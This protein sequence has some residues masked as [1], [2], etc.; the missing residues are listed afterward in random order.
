MRSKFSEKP[1]ED[2]TETHVKRCSLSTTAIDEIVTAMQGEVAVHARD[3]PAWGRPTFGP[4][5]SPRFGACSWPD[6]SEQGTTHWICDQKGLIALDALKAGRIER[7]PVTANY[8]NLTAMPYVIP[9]EEIAAEFARDPDGDD[10]GLAVCHRLAPR[11]MAFLE[12]ALGDNPDAVVQLQRFAG[13]CLTFDMKFETICFLFGPSGS[14]KGT[15]L[16]VLIELVGQRNAVATSYGE[17]CNRF[18]LIRLIGKPLAYIDEAGAIGHS[19][20]GVE[21][22]RRLKTF[23]A[24]T[25]MG[26]EAKHGAKDDFTPVSKLVLAADQMP[27]LTDAAA[28]MARRLLVIPFVQSH[29]GRE[30]YDLKRKLKAEIAGVAAWAIFGLRSLYRVGRF[31]QPAKGAE[32]LGELQR[33]WSPV[34]AFCEDCVVTQAGSRCTKEV[35]YDLY[36]AW[37]ENEGFEPRTKETFSAQLKAAVPTVRVGRH[38]SGGGDPVPWFEGVRPKLRRDDYEH[39]RFE[40]HAVD[41]GARSLMGPFDF[42]Y[43]PNQYADHGPALIPT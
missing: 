4:D 6:F 5:G 40:A 7:R 14:G 8:I 37:C 28:A 18:E 25:P 24:G 20:D 3:L 30:D 35:M 39:R 9:V 36:R 42:E 16:E 38:R 29:K 12:E 1:I 33:L 26:A 11:F 31:I 32:I 19:V 23:S 15:F 43:P 2:L 41:M 13:L 22:N 10:D 27:R 17:F 21:A 34:H